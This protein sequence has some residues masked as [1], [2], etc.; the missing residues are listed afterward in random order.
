MSFEFCFFTGDK[1]I[2]ASPRRCSLFG[3]GLVGVVVCM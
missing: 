3:W 1:P 2:G